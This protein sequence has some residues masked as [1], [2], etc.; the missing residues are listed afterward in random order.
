LGCWAHG[1]NLWIKDIMKLTWSENLLQ[2][3]KYIINYFRK[4]QV[5][6]AVLRRL[7]MEKYGTHIALLLPGRTRWGSAYYCIRSLIKTKVALLNTLYEEEIE[8]DLQIKQKILDDSFWQNLRIL[9]D[10]LEPFVKFINQLQSDQPRLSTAYSNLRKIE[11]LITQN[12]EIPNDVQQK[13]CEFGKSRWNNFLY[14]PIVMVAYKLDP[15]YCGETLNATQ[16]DRFLEH[17]IIQMTPENEHDAIIMEYSE[18][19]GKL[20]GFSENH[21]W[22]NLTKK[23]I[24]WWKLVARQYPVLSK[25]AL[26]VLSIPATSA[27]SERNWSAFGFIHNK[28]RNRM[29]DQKVEKCVY[30]YW[31]IKVMREIKGK[32]ERNITSELE[33]I[34]VDKDNN[35][36]FNNFFIDDFYVNELD[37]ESDND[38]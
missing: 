29:L 9:C 10:F 18:Y 14:N 32:K 16:W 6:L 25:I 22:G 15:Q 27:A 24:N 26:K 2:F 7:Q 4:H 33:N 11:Q 21:L 35:D 36:Q 23:P 37:I 5:L 34:E 1:I 12:S 8:V 19:V 20:G 13:S 30:L 17:K 28:L 3:A 38:E 31:N